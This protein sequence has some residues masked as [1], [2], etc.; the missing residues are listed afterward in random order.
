MPLVTD[1]NDRETF[2]GILDRLEVNLSDQ[3]TGR[4]EGVE[5]TTARR[6]PN[7]GRDPMGRKQHHAPLGNVL[8][9]IDEHRTFVAERADHVLVMHNLVVHVDRGAKLL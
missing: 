7:L 9:R 8:D 1:Q 2:P 6:L 5:M 3:G 4:V